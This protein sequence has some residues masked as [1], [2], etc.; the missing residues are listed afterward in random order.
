[1]NHSIKLIKSANTDEQYGILI[2]K[3]IGI[4]N[5]GKVYKAVN[6]ANSEDQLAVKV[7]PIKD[8]INKTLVE[9]EINVLKQLPEHPNLIN[10]K[11]FKYFSD[12]NLYILMDY[13]NFTLQ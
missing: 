1:M 10:I 2:D 12:E 6:L 7:L 11:P 8:G 4:G 5:F 13:C 3:E 9:R